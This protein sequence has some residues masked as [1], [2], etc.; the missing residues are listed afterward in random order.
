ML[1]RWKEK[2]IGASLEV[3]HFH[4]LAMVATQIPP[5]GDGGYSLVATSLGMDRCG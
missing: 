2:V 5:S 1:M 4:H 3:S